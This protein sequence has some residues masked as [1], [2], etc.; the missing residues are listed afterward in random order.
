MKTSS[1]PMQCDHMPVRLTSPLMLYAAAWME[2]S[3]K[4]TY[5]LAKR[6][7]PLRTCSVRMKSWTSKHRIYR[8]KDIN[9]P[10]GLWKSAKP[11]L[12]FPKLWKITKHKEVSIA[13]RPWPHLCK[14]SQDWDKKLST[15]NNKNRIWDAKKISLKQENWHWKIRCRNKRRRSA[16]CEGLSLN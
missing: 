8:F 13:R 9:C 12:L 16:N 11:M 14:T 2:V 10:R 1:L 4:K 3:F 7:R 5:K 6:M 15:E